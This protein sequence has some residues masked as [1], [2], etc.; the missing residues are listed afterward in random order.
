MSEKYGAL[1]EQGD[2]GLGFNVFDDEEQKALEKKYAEE[3]KKNVEAEK[4]NK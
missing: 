2:L 3:R 4:K 1:N